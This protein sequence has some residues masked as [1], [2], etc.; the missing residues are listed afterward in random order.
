MTAM[1][2]DTTAHWKQAIRTGEFWGR[3]MLLWMLVGAPAIVVGAT[4]STLV[5]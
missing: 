2:R 4:L 5:R 3:L 1:L